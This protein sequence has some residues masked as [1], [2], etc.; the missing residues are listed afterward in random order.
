MAE[1]MANLNQTADDVFA[2]TESMPRQAGTLRQAPKSVPKR[3]AKTAGTGARKSQELLS[4]VEGDCLLR[5]LQTYRQ[6]LEAKNND[7]HWVDWEFWLD[8]HEV[9]RYCSPSCQMVTGYLASDFENDATLLHRIVHPDDLDKYEQHHHGLKTAKIYDEIEFRI[10]HADES[11]RWLSHVCRPVYTATGRYLGT[12]GSN[13]DITKRKIQEAEMVKTKTLESL[14]ALA[15]G[16]AHDL[17]NLFQGLL[18]NISLAKICLPEASEA[19]KYLAS[20]ENVYEQATQLTSQLLAFSTGGAPRRVATQLA[21]YI[22]QAVTANLSASEL[23]VDFK[24]ADDLWPV[25]VDPAQFLQVIDNMVTNA[26]DAMP[27]AGKIMVT[28]VNEQVSTKMLGTIPPGNFVQ[29]SI[30]DRGCGISADDLPRIFDPYFSTKQRC[31]QKGMGLGLALCNMIIQKNGGAITV[32]TERGLGTTFHIHLPAVGIVPKQTT[33]KKEMTGRSPRILVM[34]DEPAVCHVATKYL[35][36]HGYRVD[37]AANGA[38]AI[39][40]YQDAQVKDDPYLAVIL[41]LSIPG[42]MGG[43]EVFAILKENDPQVKAIVSSGYSSDPAMI[44]Y[45]AHG[46]VEVLVK[47]YPLSKMKEVLDRFI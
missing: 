27:T 36:Q 46:F 14:S 8:Q 29:I 2:Q 9:I 47:P 30:Q 40:A 3:T 4:P 33:I 37:S 6:E 7:L 10:I 26:R 34:D 43:K 18:G 13:R 42:G 28:A 12:R 39:A 20:A 45:A 24:M 38:A 5:D 1:E 16:I 15:G 21:P 22:R 35:C 23:T 25:K 41:D 11:V 32:E 19:Y 17:N 44:D 31:A